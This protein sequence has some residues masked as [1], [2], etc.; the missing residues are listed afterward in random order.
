MKILTL[1]I[2]LVL[3]PG[4]SQAA[5]NMF[6]KIEGVTG[7]SLQKDHVGEIDVLAWSWG[8]SS[9]KNRRV[10]IE[11]LFLT[12]WVDSASPVLLMNQIEG[13]VYPT[14]T[15]AV[16]SAGGESNLDYIVLNFQNFYISSLSSGGSVG[17]NRLTENVTF[18]FDEVEYIYTPQEDDHSPGTEIRATIRSKRCKN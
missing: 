4:L 1:L 17:D 16:M 14:A 9:V 10:C 13:V 2:L 11:D 3:V 18:G 12:K 8:G 5:N 6:L 7:E 15:L